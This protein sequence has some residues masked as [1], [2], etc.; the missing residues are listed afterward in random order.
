[1][2][3]GALAS[4]TEPATTPVYSA[5]NG[6]WNSGTGVFTPTSGNPSLSVTAG[7]FA[8]VFVDGSTTPTRIARVTSVN[9]T[10][11]TL[12]TTAGVGTAP[13][14]AGRGVFFNSGGGWGGAGGGGG[15]S[16]SFSNRAGG[17]AQGGGM[18]GKNKKN[19]T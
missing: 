9:S 5:T 14:T 16:F 3:G 6:G 8:H 11:V 7:D 15:V 2:N 13:T 17:V 12:S 4:N 18:C 19:T 1:M 10:T